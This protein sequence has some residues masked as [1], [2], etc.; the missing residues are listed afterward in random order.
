MRLVGLVATGRLS[1]VIAD[2]FLIALNG[3]GPDA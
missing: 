1:S 3:L 2:C